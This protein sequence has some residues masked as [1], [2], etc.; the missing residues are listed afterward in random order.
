MYDKLDMSYTV[1]GLLT[2]MRIELLIMM[3]LVETFALLSLMTKF[4]LEDDNTV[5]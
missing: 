4:F 5:I 2:R 3:A 1:V